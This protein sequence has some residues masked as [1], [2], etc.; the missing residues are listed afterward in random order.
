MRSLGGVIGR[1]RRCSAVAAQVDAATADDDGGRSPARRTGRRRRCRRR[2]RR[3]GFVLDRRAARKAASR[4]GRLRPRGP[5]AGRAGH[6]RRVSPAAEV[7][8]AAT[9]SRPLEP[10]R[11]L[12]RHVAEAARAAAEAATPQRGEVETAGDGASRARAGRR[13]A[14]TRG[15]AP[16]SAPRSRL[17][18]RDDVAHRATV[19]CPHRPRRLTSA[20]RGPRRRRSPGSTATSTSRRSGRRRSKALSLD[21]MRALVDVL[22]DP[23][24]AV[25]GHPRHRHQRQ[26][27]DGPHGHRAAR[28][29]RPDGRHLHQ[30]APRAHQRAH[31]PQ[32]RADRRRRPRRGCSPT[33]RALEAAA[34]RRSD[35]YFELLTA[36]ALRAGSPTSPSTSP[37]SRSACSVA[38]TPPTSPTAPSRWSPTSAPTTPTSRATGAARHRRGE[39]GHRQ[40]GAARSCSARP[41]PSCAPIF[42]RAGRRRGRGSATRDFG[43]ERNERRRRRPAARPAHARRRATTTCSCPLHGAHQGDNAARRAGRGRGVLRPPL[44]DDVV[45]RGVRVGRDAGPV[46]G[47]RPRRRSSCS[48]APTTP[49]ARAAAAATLDEDFDVAGE[50][51]LVV[52]HAAGRAIPSAVL[53]ALEVDARRGSSIACAAATRRGRMPAERGRRRRRG[54][55]RR[56]ADVEPRRRRRRRPGPARVASRRRRR[57]RHRLALRRAAT[58]RSRTACR[59]RAR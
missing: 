40:A 59:R 26:G 32:R 51:I 55:R 42:D 57:A 27:L 16:P 11:E 14:S 47:R 23:Q 3:S 29:S 4:A 18:G 12:A 7:A 17:A 54:A 6:R 41:T 25:P 50:P 8:P 58:A 53:E 33:S 21:R 31:H 43:C 9:S 56:R 19:E 36:A 2:R 24:H 45:A 10:P 13:A 39:G 44:D 38:T 46:R 34:R 22:G 5:P 15:A 1:R 49:T 37:S 35:S 28:E 30:P 52:G 48:T 20:A